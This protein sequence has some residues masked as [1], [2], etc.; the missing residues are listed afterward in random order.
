MV[1]TGNAGCNG[2]D[3]FEADSLVSYCATFPTV[4][5]GISWLLVV[6]GMY[7]FSFFLLGRLKVHFAYGYTHCS[8]TSVMLVVI[9]SETNPGLSREQ[10]E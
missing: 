2:T 3:P 8:H 7:T 9:M 5:A 4:L 1:A 6:Q 10:H